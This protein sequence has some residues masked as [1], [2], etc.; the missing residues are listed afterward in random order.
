M[1][2]NMSLEGLLNEIKASC[3]TQKGRGRMAELLL[4]NG[5]LTQLMKKHLDGGMPDCRVTSTDQL[6]AH[7]VPLDEY[8][9]SRN[10]SHD[11]PDVR[12]VLG[13]LHIWTGAARFASTSAFCS[14]SDAAIN[15]NT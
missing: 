14:N 8:V 3:P 2:T 11:R 9:A 6:R 13:Q 4:H 1:G 7:G 5:T 12:Y 15:M 10:L